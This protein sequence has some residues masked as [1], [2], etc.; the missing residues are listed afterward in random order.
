VGLRYAPTHPT[1]LKSKKI[2]LIIEGD[3]H[4]RFSVNQEILEEAKPRHQNQTAP[5]R[6]L[7]FEYGKGVATLWENSPAHLMDYTE[8]LKSTKKLALGTLSSPHVY[9][10]LESVCEQALSW[11]FYNANDMDVRAIKHEFSEWTFL[12]W[13]HLVYFFY[14]VNS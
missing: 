8:N 4:G 1:N 2:R 5:Y 9:P 11:H 3:N 14:S 7:A 6:H 12:V 13:Y 10:V